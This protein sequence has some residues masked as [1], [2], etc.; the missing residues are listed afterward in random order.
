MEFLQPPRG[1]SLDRPPCYRGRWTS[2][3]CL[4]SDAFQEQT[5]LSIFTM[6]GMASR[7]PHRAASRNAHPFLSNI[8]LPSGLRIANPLDGHEPKRLLP[9]A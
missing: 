3:G 7:R 9:E 6:R 1:R 5:I 8:D 2:G 4:G